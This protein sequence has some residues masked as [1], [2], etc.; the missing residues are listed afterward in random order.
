MGNDGLIIPYLI[1]LRYALL[2]KQAL[3]FIDSSIHDLY[4]YSRFY[5]KNAPASLASAKKLLN[6]LDNTEAV[7]SS[8]FNDLC[9][10]LSEFVVSLPFVD[11]DEF[12]NIDEHNPFN[13]FGQD[14]LYRYF[15]GSGHVPAYLDQ[16]SDDACLFFLNDSYKYYDWFN[17]IEDKAIKN[18]LN[19]Y[20]EKLSLYLCGETTPIVARGS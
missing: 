11:Q 14:V 10:R 18:I 8:S 3:A 15:H 9:K 5:E 1:V 20:I 19:I 6:F 17:H 7:E 12:R 13:D 2:P 16:T 4:S